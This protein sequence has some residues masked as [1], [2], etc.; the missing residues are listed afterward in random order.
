MMM[1]FWAAAAALM[2]GALWF[3]IPPLLNSREAAEPAHR[4]TLLALHRDR[5]AELEAD[6]ERGTLSPAQFDEA[7][8]DLERQLLTDLVADRAAAVPAA[9][10]QPSWLPRAL[11][12]ALPLA[13]VTFFLGHQQGGRELPQALA[14]APPAMGAPAV[15]EAAA[16]PHP[17]AGAQAGD[18]G[19][20]AQAMS[21]EEAVV[22]LE[23]RLKDKPD[24][25]D[26]WLL[27]GNSYRYLGKRRE[28]DEAF[29]R[30]A[31][32]GKT[33]PPAPTPQA[34]ASAVPTDSPASAPDTSATPPATAPAADD[35]ALAALTSK[36][37]KNP[38]DAQ[39]WAALANLHQQKKR[40]SDAA[41]AW[42]HALAIDPQQAD[43]LAA[44]AD[45]LGSA[46][47][48]LEGEPLALIGQALDKDPNHVK[49]LWLA[50]SAAR[51]RGQ[52]GEAL[53]LWQRLAKVLPP[54]SDDARIIAANIEEAR[55]D[56]SRET[57][58]PPSTGPPAANTVAAIHGVVVIDGELGKELA[59]DETLFVFARAVDGPPMPLAVL[60]KR[61]ADLPLS[62]TLDDSMS[63][64]PAAKLSDAQEVVVGAR[65]SKSGNA[66]AQPGDMQGWSG[67]V[68]VK[69]GVE[70]R[71]V[72]DRR[73]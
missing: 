47:G 51:Q 32:L 12:L 57:S 6:R 11:A 64:M 66:I 29:A 45:A 13:A 17:A 37:E 52:H 65:V 73:T 22:R 21:M 56:A 36:L 18:S 16:K 19:A 61:A 59:G 26:G 43:W 39:G 49:A 41:A 1:E 60:K 44:A 63:L 7:R 40:Y 15:G 14:T 68:Q 53:A 10:P 5:L 58:P 50:A 55:A 38:A 48:S 35:E 2:A 54:A 67:T 25:G 33:P 23:K 3:V 42:R 62:F 71:I 8:A 24:D 28:A 46:A 9:R 70:V 27:L 69:S 20:P 72:I 30:A 34:T 4:D 31:K